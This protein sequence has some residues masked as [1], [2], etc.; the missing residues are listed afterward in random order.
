MVKTKTIR[1]RIG[2]IS[3]SH[4]D[5]TSV[6]KAIDIFF[7]N[8]IKVAIHAGDIISP[9]IV[10]EFKRLTDQDVKFFG[11][12]GNNDGEKRGLENAFSFI[13]GELLGDIGKIEIDNMKICIY[14]GQDLKKKEKL[15]SSQ[16]FDVFIYGHS[17]VK[18][19]EKRIMKKRETLILNPG[20]SHGEATTRFSDPPYFPKPSI[21]IFDTVSK[22]VKFIDL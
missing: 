17:H 1:M 11:V 5:V 3:D 20:S 8:D 19:S 22:E 21:I 15:I 4:D 7:D 9:P 6:N 16:K 10:N 2:I 13:S 14:H 12:F 18:D